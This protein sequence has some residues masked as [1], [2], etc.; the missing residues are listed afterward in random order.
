MASQY[1]STEKWEFDT[2]LS[3]AGQDTR[4]NFIRPLHKRLQETGI[5][6]FKDDEKVGKGRFILTELFSA[7]ENSRSAVIVFSEKYASSTWCLEELSKIN[8]RIETKGL[9][10]EIALV[11]HWRNLRRSYTLLI[12][13]SYRGGRTLY[14]KHPTLQVQMLV[15][16][17]KG[18]GEEKCIELIVKEIY[19]CVEGGVSTIVKYQ[20]G[21]ESHVNKVESLLKVGLDGVHFVGIFGRAGEG[22]TTVARAIFDKISCQFEGSCFLTNV[23]GVSNK[24]ET[25]GLKYLQENLLL[26][27][28]GL[29][30]AVLHLTN[31]DEGVKMIRTMLRSKRLLI[32]LDEVDDDKQLECLVGRRDWFGDGTRII[33]TTRN[34][35]LLH[36][37]DKLYSVPEA[38][39]EALELFSWY[40]FQQGT[41]NKEFEK[42]SFSVVNYASGLPLVLE[43]LGSFLYGRGTEEWKSTVERL[44]DTGG[45]RNVVKQ[46]S[47]SLDGLDDEDKNIFLHIACSYKGKK[48]R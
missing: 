43:V 10:I 26:Q 19:R 44:E 12:W 42:P 16:L 7:I 1:K 31:V 46:L 14:A 35:D 45:D 21:I 24:H 8:E 39:H 29:E 13:K 20:V 32:V 28:L 2:F 23:K 33:T 40:A 18:K 34:A 3:F 9:K 25:E 37:H 48:E 41:P 4:D 27:I 22:K 17:L 5:S 30:H 6:V 36:S 38:R 47:L 15:K 11:E